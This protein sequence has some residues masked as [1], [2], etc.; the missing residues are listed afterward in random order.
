MAGCGCR[1]DAARVLYRLRLRRLLVRD[2]SER[3]CDVPPRRDP[4]ADT[5]CAPRLLCATQP[6]GASQLTVA[7]AAPL[8]LVLLRLAETAVGVAVLGR[9]PVAAGWCE[10]ADSVAD[11]EGTHGHPSYYG[12]A[13]T[14]DGTH[15]RV[16]ARNGT[17]LGF[18]QAQRAVYE[19][20]VAMTVS[21][22]AP[23]RDLH[24]ACMPSA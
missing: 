11:L 16:V 3:D 1:R 19:A 20:M 2:R 24:D 17:V 9:C 5:A 7:P 8:Q 10:V 18:R 23:R 14:K 12:Y 13:V 22:D 15:A 6:L 21:P 4:N